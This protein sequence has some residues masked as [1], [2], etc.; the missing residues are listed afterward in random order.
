MIPSPRSVD[1]IERE[2]AS[3]ILVIKLNVIFFARYKQAREIIG[4][5]DYLKNDCEIYR[6]LDSLAGS[7][8]TRVN[9]NRNDRVSLNEGVF[10]R[11]HKIEIRLIYEDDD[12]RSSLGTIVSRSEFFCAN[13]SRLS[14]RRSSFAEG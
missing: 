12:T 5:I 8:S 11:F 10:E 13:F 3:T 14:G 4:T 6:D 2:T 9:S 1:I 7:L